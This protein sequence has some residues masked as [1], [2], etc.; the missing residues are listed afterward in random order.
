MQALNQFLEQKRDQF[1]RLY[2]LSNEELVDIFGNSSNDD[3]E[4]LKQETY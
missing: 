3:E 1:P 4:D 2:F